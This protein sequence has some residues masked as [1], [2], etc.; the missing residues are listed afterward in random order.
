[1]ATFSKR[2]R[3]ALKFRA[4]EAQRHAMGAIVIRK[5]MHRAANPEGERP[6]A[7]QAPPTMPNKKN[8]LGNK[9]NEHLASPS[10]CK[11]Q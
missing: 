7:M 11:V 3:V 10:T 2:P 9:A 6:T 1:M 8:T 5:T 4:T